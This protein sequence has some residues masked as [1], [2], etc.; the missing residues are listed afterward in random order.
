MSAK[1]IGA[2][3]PTSGGLDKAVKNGKGIGCT[4]VQVFTSSPQ[5]WRSKDVSDEMASHLQEALKETGIRQIVSHDS[6]LINLCAVKNEIKEKSRAALSRELTRCAKLGIPYVVSHVGSHMGQGVDEGIKICA[7]ALKE[8]LEETPEEATVLAE[9]T[10]GQGTALYSRFEE[11]AK[12]I[13]LAGDPKRLQICLDTCHIFVA[14]Y[15]LRDED[16]YE[17]T[18]EEFERLIGCDRIKCIHA[19]D[20]KAE[21]GSHKDRHEHIGDGNI[22]NEGFRLLVN[23][24][25]FE[26]TPIVLETPKADEM[27]EEN[28]NRL[29]KLV[30][31]A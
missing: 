15:D 16:A 29:W 13:E 10:A 4:A 6:Y 14:G 28:V 19:N 20:A 8:I 23:D 24:K 5:Q 2:H 22:G 30:G 26:E 25:R 12:L 31:K 17:K 27:H 11:L 21:L 1:Y 7:E 9:T 3:M 18:F